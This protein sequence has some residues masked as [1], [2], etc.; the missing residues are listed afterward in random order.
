MKV[1]VQTWSLLSECRMYVLEWFHLKRG[2]AHA[3]EQ[4]IE[5]GWNSCVFVGTS[6]VVG[7]SLEDAWRMFN[8]MPSQNVVTWTTMGL[9]DGKCGKCKRHWH[10]LTNETRCLATKLCYLLAW[11]H[12]KRAVVLMSRSTK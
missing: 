11:L 10:H 9:G 3:H 8:K 4:T 5:S 12:L 6:L 7:T 1:C 2:Q